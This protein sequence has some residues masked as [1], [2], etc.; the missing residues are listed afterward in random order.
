MNRYSYAGNDPV[1]LIDPSG[2]EQCY[3]V[4]LITVIREP[5]R[6][7][8]EIGRRVLFTF[9]V[10]SPRS[11]THRIP[12]DDRWDPQTQKIVRTDKML[13]R[14]TP[15]A[16]AALKRKQ[17]EEYDRKKREYEKCKSQAEEIFT[18]LTAFNNK[19]QRDNETHPAALGA[20]VISLLM[21]DVGSTL[22]SV[23]TV[24][25]YHGMYNKGLEQGRK[26]QLES[27]EQLNP[28]PG[29]VTLTPTIR[30]GRR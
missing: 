16:I 14:A 18:V 21:G 1:N 6:P 29:T 22:M 24:A 17:Q 28:G 30:N 25:F 26:A 12:G 4:V 11:T 27:C 13:Q 20:L 5:R 19:A 9:C 8:V 10:E 7:D 15:E 2:L 3:S 23:G